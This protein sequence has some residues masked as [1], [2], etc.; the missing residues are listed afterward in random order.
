[1]IEYD[2]PKERLQI[3]VFYEDE[4]ARR[5]E[6]TPVGERYEQLCKELFA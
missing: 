3:E 2:L 1:L 6:I 5:F 4:F